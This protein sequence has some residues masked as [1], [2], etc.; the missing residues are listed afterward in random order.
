MKTPSPLSETAHSILQTYC[1]GC[2]DSHPVRLV[3]GV[4][5]VKGHKCVTLKTATSEAIEL[6]VRLWARH[7]G[8]RLAYN[9]KNRARYQEQLE[10]ELKVLQAKVDDGARD[11]AELDAQ[12]AAVPEILAYLNPAPTSAAKTDT[13]EEE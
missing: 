13:T 2:K 3:K 7:E 4:W 11:I 12:I 8:E 10:R 6:G 9:R 5:Q 1:G